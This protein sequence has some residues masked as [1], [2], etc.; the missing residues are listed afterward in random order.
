ME[1]NQEKVNDRSG[2]NK[3]LRKHWR[4]IDIHVCSQYNIAIKTLL[5]IFDY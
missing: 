4:V 3:R 2:E 5:L 1:E